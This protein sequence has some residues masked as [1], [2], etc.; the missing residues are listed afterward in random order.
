[1]IQSSHKE[2]Q[3]YS[4]R[5]NKLLAGHYFTQRRGQMNGGCAPCLWKQNSRSTQ[6]QPNSHRGQEKEKSIIFALFKRHW[7]GCN[8][9][10]SKPSCRLFSKY[11]KIQSRPRGSVSDNCGPKEDPVSEQKEHLMWSHVGLYETDIGILYYYQW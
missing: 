1:M 6:T 10:C 9:F 11:K 2:V 7:T 4:H 8:I 3:S 5:L